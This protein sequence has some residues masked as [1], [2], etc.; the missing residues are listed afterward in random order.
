MK[1]YFNIVVVNWSLLFLLLLCE[2][3]MLESFVLPSK[4]TTH[5]KYYHS[6]Q[7]LFSKDRNRRQSF[8]MS[9]SE[10]S[11][12]SDSDSTYSNSNSITITTPPFYPNSKSPLHKNTH[13]S[14]LH[15]I[16]ILPSFLT[17]TESSKCL[18]ISQSY[19][20]QSSC[21]DQK[22][23]KRH[24]SYATV[25]FPIE[26]C[27]ALNDY[28]SAIN[29]DDRLWNLIAEMYDVD[30]EDLSFLDFFVVHYQAKP[31]DNDDD[32]EESFVMDSLD[33]HRDGSMIS[34][35]IVVSNDD[36]FAVSEL[37]DVVPSMTRNASSL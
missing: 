9:T 37:T 5:L 23:S 4:S 34:F 15:T 2:A 6:N 24:S 8:Y 13:P 12:P 11:K 33:P 19:A 28:L 20:Q 16:H 27:D 7:S 26:D 3:T 36:S 17:P 29:F 10:T 22:D 21:W 18:T 25:D 1:L 31:N 35:T 14:P 30:V 32:E